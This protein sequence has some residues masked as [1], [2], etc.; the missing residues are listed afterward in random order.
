MLKKNINRHFGLINEISSNAYKAFN[1][2]RFTSRGGFL[3]LINY[4]IYFILSIM[5]R[6][7]LKKIY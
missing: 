6:G 1:R 4:S 5:Q 3:R 7:L 2:H